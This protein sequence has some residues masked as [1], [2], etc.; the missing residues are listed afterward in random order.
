[1]TWVY[2]IAAVLSEVVGAVATRF[3]HG[4]T[5]LLPTLV[6]LVGVLGAYYLLSLVLRRGMGIGV[7]YGIWAALGVA[8]VALI[9]VVLLEDRFTWLQGFGL[10]LTMSGV[11]ALEAGNGPADGAVGTAEDSSAP[12]Q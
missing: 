6:A 3:S 10:V 5:A 2:L 4:F 11:L 1:M 9:G 12:T 8:A 7:A